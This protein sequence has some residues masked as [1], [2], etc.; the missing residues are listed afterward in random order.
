MRR[1][2]LGL[3]LAATMACRTGSSGSIAIGSAAPDFALPGVDGQTHRLADYAA[4]PVL[5][6][7]FTCNHCPASQQYERRI[8]KL[9]DDYRSK[10]VA[11]VAINPNNPAAIPVAE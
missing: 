1:W 7:V 8:Q 6:V 2:G 9:Y 10:G 4:S 11:V 5:A 3:V